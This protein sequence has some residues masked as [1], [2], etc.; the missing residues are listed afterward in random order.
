[1]LEIMAKNIETI[2]K[3]IGNRLLKAR[4]KQG[5]TQEALAA[6]SGIASAHIGFIEQGHRRPTLSTLHKLCSPLDLTLETLFKGL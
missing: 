1:M 2:Y 5:L 3:E 6:E 4:R